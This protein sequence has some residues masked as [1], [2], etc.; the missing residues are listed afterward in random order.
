MFL[1]LC[2]QGCETGGPTSGVIPQAVPTLF[3]ESL[4]DLKLI[5]L[6]GPAL[7]GVPGLPLSL[8]PALGLQPCPDF[9]RVV[10]I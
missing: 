4:P 2:A 8:S 1:H 7:H 10:G 3:S 6:T 9:I 5:K